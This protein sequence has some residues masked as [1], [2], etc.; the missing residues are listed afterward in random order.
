[1]PIQKIPYTDYEFSPNET[2]EY[3]YDFLKSMDTAQFQTHLKN[4]RESL[5]DRYRIKHSIFKDH[6]F[7]LFCIGSA[8][9]LT[10]YIVE[11]LSSWTI[12]E[13]LMFIPFGFILF[14]L[15]GLWSYILTRGAF[16]NFIISTVAYERYRKELVDMAPSFSAFHKFEARKLQSN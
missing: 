4:V 1:M 3:Q 2:E 16:K 9:G 15:P 12:S 14:S 5:W 6:F 7:H 10:S 11:K 8:I 13:W